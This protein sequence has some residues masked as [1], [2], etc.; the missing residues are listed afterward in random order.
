M[1][2]E[3]VPLSVIGSV[4]PELL[5]AHPISGEQPTQRW[6]R[7]ALGLIVAFSA[8]LNFFLIQENGYGNE[9]YAATVRSMLES[10][11]NFFFASFD[12]SGFV[13]VDKPALG[14]WIQTLSAKIAELLGFGFS[15][16]SLLVPQAIAGT[17]SVF[18]IYR[19]V[20][21]SF[22]PIPGLIA[23]LALSITPITVTMN[24]DNNLDP[25]LILTLLLAVWCVLLA[26]STGRLRWLVLCAVLVG[27][28][29][30]I[31]TLEAYLVLPAIGL[32][33]LLSAPH[34]W[35][36][37]IGYLAV[38]L[39]VLLV[40]SFSWLIAVDLTPASERPYVGSSQ[41]NSEIEL[42]FGYNGLQR[43]T[44]MNAGG[45]ARGGGGTVTASTMPPANAG[46][47]NAAAPTGSFGGGGG[48]NIF[49]EG[50]APSVFRLFKPEL[51][52]QVSW[53]LPLAL[54]GMLAMAWQ[55]RLRWPLQRWHQNL[56]LWG[57][58]LFTCGGFFSVAGFY[59]SYY[60]VTIAP[61]I[62]GLAAI[63]LV[64]LWHEYRTRA[65]SDWRAWILPLAIVLTLA[66][67]IYLLTA[68]GTPWS[69]ILIPILAILG[70]LG[71][72]AL[73]LTKV[74]WQFKLSALKIQLPAVMVGMAVLL[75]TPLVWS[76][77]SVSAPGNSTLPTSGPALAS[78]DRGG[79]G[80]GI[81]TG[82]RGGFGAGIR[83]GDTGTKSGFPG[84]T[85]GF[86]PPTGAGR[87]GGLPDGG[88]TANVKLEQFIQTHQGSAR[89]ALAVTN[90][91]AA[92]RIIID[93]GAQLMT[94][95]GFSGSDPILTQQKL[96]QLV[97]SGQV[98]YF[99]LSSQGNISEILDQLPAAAREEIESATGGRGFGG[100]G[101][102]GGQS[103]LTSWVQNNCKIVPT[104]EWSSS[105]TSS[106]GDFGFGGG[107]NQ[108]LYDCS[109][110]K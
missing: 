51:G 102:F 87:A 34:S 82:D 27:L 44:G 56:L 45:G 12:P 19:L 69:T 96:T 53:L 80:A 7:I 50:G 75:V 92:E 65:R 46:S 58:W 93:T 10:W 55:S 11:H 38:A 17:L 5:D 28:G 1:K 77:I 76:L 99:L 104:S 16:V 90:A 101:G 89:Y 13:T 81:R 33:Y 109:A 48:G 32:Y 57:V 94:M 64:T 26:V 79:F 18:I 72:L 88:S 14:L 20:R 73:I 85:G 98:R 59:H 52:G 40:V 95:G 4:G 61:P 70:A 37:R 84:A 100:F 68:Y 74:R 105:T 54:L 86:T 23:A 3:D 66:E 21:H 8:F 31:K 60:L 25:L 110:L 24:R 71:V 47:G 106:T 49:N 9:F 107:Q 29:F 35:K 63:G 67:Q 78:S 36:K 6:H 15:S 108:H 22:G 91:S 103:Q 39:V 62:C 97:K 30:N 41:T 43:L 2:T 83:T 42:A